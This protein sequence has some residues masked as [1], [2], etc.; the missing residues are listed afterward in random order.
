[1]FNRRRR[2]LPAYSV[3][4]RRRRSGCVATQRVEPADILMLWLNADQCVLHGAASEKYYGGN[5]PHAIFRC[6][7]RMFIDVQLAHLHTLRIA[8]RERIDGRPQG[9]ARTAP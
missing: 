4:T 8:V 6:D 7:G 3:A 5:R 1:M 2:M 9:L